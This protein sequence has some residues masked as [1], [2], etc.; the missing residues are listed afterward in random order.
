MGQTAPVAKKL[1]YESGIQ[2]KQRKSASAVAAAGAPDEEASPFVLIE[3]EADDDLAAADRPVAAFAPVDEI[4]PEGP[5]PLEED[6]VLTLAD[7]PDLDEVGGEV[8]LESAGLVSEG[9]LDGFVAR[10]GP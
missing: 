7:Y 6:V 3:D 5:P 4:A 10:F 9:G 1:P 8:E 2:E